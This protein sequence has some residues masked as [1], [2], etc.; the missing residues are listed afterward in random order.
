MVISFVP[1]RFNSLQTRQMSYLQ[2]F[3][4]R[5]WNLRCI[6]PHRQLYSTNCS[7]T[8]ST[9]S[10]F[11]NAFYS[12]KTKLK[13]ATR[14]SKFCLPAL[15]TNDRALCSSCV[16]SCGLATVNP[17]RSNTTKVSSTVPVQKKSAPAK[18]KRIVKVVPEKQASPTFMDCIYKIL[19]RNYCN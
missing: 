12:K 1:R 10:T 2:L 17:R 4:N 6:K 16:G 11:N 13:L 8:C 18:R 19:V 3:S 14:Q 15:V 7:T 9:T 5:L